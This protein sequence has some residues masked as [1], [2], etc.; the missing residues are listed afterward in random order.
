MNFISWRILK[1]LNW[2]LLR[3]RSL[4]CMLERRR[5]V[6]LLHFVNLLK[7]MMQH[8]IRSWT[9]FGNL[10]LGWSNRCWRRGRLLFAPGN[11]NGCSF[12]GL[13]WL[14]KSSRIGLRETCISWARFWSLNFM[15]SRF[16]FNSLHHSFGRTLLLFSTFS[17]ACYECLLF[18]LMLLCVLLYCIS[19]LI[20]LTVFTHYR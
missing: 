7:H 1:F 16:V 8:L 12:C 19:S 6:L 4:V 10:R 5:W 17:F 9:L 11:E 3:R 14:L 15:L 13:S 2:S 18:N 20:P